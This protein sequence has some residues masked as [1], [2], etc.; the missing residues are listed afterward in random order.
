M[1]KITLRKNLRSL[2]FFLVANGRN[3]ANTVCQLLL[4]SCTAISFAIASSYV[5]RLASIATSTISPSNAAAFS[6]NL[7]L[8]FA[9]FFQDASTSARMFGRESN[10]GLG[11][12]KVSC[13]HCVVSTFNC[14]T[15]SQCVTN[16]FQPHTCF[17]SLLYAVQSY[18]QLQ[19]HGNPQQ[20]LTERLYAA[21]W[22]S[23][24]IA[25]LSSSPNATIY[26]WI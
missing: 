24:T 22:T 2:L 13:R 16:N 10:D 3:S 20:P 21:S 25:F 23:A 8:P 14:T 18:R 15:L 7:S 9:K 5:G 26:S 17:T 1:Y 12:L 19:R 11:P 6:S 4:L